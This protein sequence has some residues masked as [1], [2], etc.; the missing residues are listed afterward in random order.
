LFGKTQI[1]SREAKA[2]TKPTTTR[3][4]GAA[5]GGHRSIGMGKR[6]SLQ[7]D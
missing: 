1:D 3:L 2:M 7:Q 6:G 5:P 4:P